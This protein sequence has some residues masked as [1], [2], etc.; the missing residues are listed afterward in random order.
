MINYFY[1]GF[2]FVW[3]TE[4]NSR[5]RSSFSIDHREHL[6]NLK[7]LSFS[8]LPDSKKKIVQSNKK[9]SKYSVDYT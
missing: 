2:C 1:S 7:F 9:S 5:E 3:M 6:I 8:I 4:A